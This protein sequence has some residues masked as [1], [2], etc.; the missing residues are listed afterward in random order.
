M[1]VFIASGDLAPFAVIEAAKAEAMIE[2]A[3]A[4]ALAAAPCLA[5]TDKPLTDA[6][7][8]VVK[9]VLRGAILRWNTAGEGGVSAQQAGPFSV[10]LDTRQHRKGMF[11]ES[12]LSQLQALCAGTGGGKAFT[13][14]TTPSIWSAHLP[15]CSGSMGALYCSC[16]VDIAGHP[17]YE[18]GDA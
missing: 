5:S 4:V 3:E 2:D 17:I 13:I 14:D 9:A 10:S 11:I 6:Q 7:K 15:W 18:L 1:G 16:G 12:E 8:A